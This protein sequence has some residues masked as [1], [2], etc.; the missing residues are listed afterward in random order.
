MHKEYWTDGGELYL[1]KVKKRKILVSR[2]DGV[3]TY[4]ITYDTSIFRNK[5][6]IFWENIYRNR[7][8]HNIMKCPLK[9]FKIPVLVN[10]K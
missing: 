8:D 2:I 1:V 5:Y 7:L 9:Y 4:I 3:K 6:L 10:N